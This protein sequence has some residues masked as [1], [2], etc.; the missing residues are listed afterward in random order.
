MQ[1]M[2][3]MLTRWLDGNLRRQGEEGREQE[4]EAQEGNSDNQAAGGQGEGN[5][6]ER[7]SDIVNEPTSVVDGKAFLSLDRK[8]I[9]QLLCDSEGDMKIYLPMKIYIPRGLYFFFG[10]E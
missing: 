8:N 1:R 2:S 7:G 4:N 9:I 6:H 5:E 3:D 10:G